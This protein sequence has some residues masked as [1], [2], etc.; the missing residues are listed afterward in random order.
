MRIKET[1]F[2]KDI[3][4]ETTKDSLHKP[5]T[6]SISFADTLQIQSSEIDSYEH[7]IDQMRKEI[8]HAGEALSREPNLANF[9]KYKQLLSQLA[10][11]VSN[12]AYRL[13]KI[14][15]TPHNPRYFEIITVINREAE[16]LYN[17]IVSQQKENMKVIEKVIG[18]KGLVIDLIT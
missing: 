16:Q 6:S 5:S 18:I 11:R 7:E 13:E 12:E 3:V 15:G 17:Q 2:F 9:K 10:K 4:K 1:G 8:D 14:G